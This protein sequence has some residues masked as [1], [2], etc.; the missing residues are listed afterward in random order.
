MFS[1]VDRARMFDKLQKE[2]AKLRERVE[3]LELECEGWS[4]SFYAADDNSEYLQKRVEELEHTLRFALAYM[5][6]HDP[7]W[8]SSKV[9]KELD[10]KARE[11]LRRENGSQG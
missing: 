6:D 4:A 3:E 2:N 5:D 10:E 7:T 9:G 1:F 11:A 8:W